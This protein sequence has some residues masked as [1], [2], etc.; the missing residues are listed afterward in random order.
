MTATDPFVSH[1]VSLTERADRGAL[2]ALRRGLGKPPGTV[3]ETFPHVLPWV[4]ATTRRAGEGDYFLLASLFAAHPKHVRSGASLGATCRSFAAN[5]SSD[6]RF[7]RLIEANRDELPARLR[8]V[9]QL[10]RSHEAAVDYHELLSHLRNWDHDDRWVQARW[11]RDYWVPVSS[12][13]SASD[14]TTTP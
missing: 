9:I 3:S 11:A 7:R 12:E 10:A 14:L 2:A 1:L 4:P 6:L 8:Q 5:P 13:D